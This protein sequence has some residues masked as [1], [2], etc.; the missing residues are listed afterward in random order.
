MRVALA[1]LEL[2]SY[3]TTWSPAL[4]RVSERF[5]GDRPP[6]NPNA[7][8]IWLRQRYLAAVNDSD[9]ILVICQARAVYEE[10]TTRKHILV[11]EETAQ[12]R[13]D[14]ILKARGWPA[15][16]VAIALRC[17]A[18]E[19]RRIRTDHGCDPETGEPAI[20]DAKALRAKGISFRNI[21]KLLGKPESSIRYQLRH[22]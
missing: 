5:G 8:H 21:A 18:S 16:D 14:R 6:G 2:L 1:R 12:E 4:T 15:R 10:L 11:R 9:R 20:L 19:I 22:K 7:P 13:A 17:S 3:G